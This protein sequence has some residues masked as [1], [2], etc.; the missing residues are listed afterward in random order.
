MLAHPFRE[1]VLANLR[2][3]RGEL[4][5]PMTGHVTEVPIDL[6]GVTGVSRSIGRQVTLAASTTV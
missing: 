2:P 5:Q 4:L 3:Q 6:L 1:E